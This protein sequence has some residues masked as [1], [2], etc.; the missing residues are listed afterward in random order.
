M[1]LF[2]NRQLMARILWMHEMYSKVINV[3]GVVMEFGVRWGQN[4]ALFEVV[5][6]NL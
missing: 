6:G 3:P 1:G 4:L 5:A 2:I